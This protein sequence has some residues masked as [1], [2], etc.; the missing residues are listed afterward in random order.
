MVDCVF[1]GYTHNSVEYR[2]L[3]HK[4]DISDISMGTTIESRNVVCFRNFYPCKGMGKS[5]NMRTHEG[6]AI[7][8]AMLETSQHDGDDEPRRSKRS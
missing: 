5:S 4:S 6:D 1:I 8:I 3:I 2:F 7:P